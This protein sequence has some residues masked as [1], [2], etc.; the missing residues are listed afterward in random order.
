MAITCDPRGVVRM[1]VL[2]PS[3][4]C[5][6]FVVTV[7]MR[8]SGRAKARAMPWRGTA[9]GWKDSCRASSSTPSFRPTPTLLPFS[10]WGATENVSSCLICPRRAS[11]CPKSSCL[12]TTKNRDSPDI[13]TSKPR[14]C[15]DPLSVQGGE[16]IFCPRISTC[17]LFPPRQTPMPWVSMQNTHPT[18]VL[19]P[20]L[21]LSLFGPGLF[22]F[23]GL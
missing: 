22:P 2:C 17:S 6:F 9:R 7:V 15:R 12:A 18:P 19:P 3:W 8:G 14:A 21:P 1:I 23:A 10:R 5:W 13:A 11:L 16:R 20:L 4:C